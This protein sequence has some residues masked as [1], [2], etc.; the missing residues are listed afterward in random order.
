MKQNKQSLLIIGVT[1]GIGAGKSEVLAY[2]EK[3]YNC[4]VY[5]ADQVAHLVK[6]VGGEAY[7][8]LVELLGEDVLCED[9]S[10]SKNQMAE[11]IFSDQTLLKQ[12]NQIVHPAVKRFILNVIEE[13]KAKQDIELLFIE[14]ALLIEAGYIDVVDELW[15]IFADIETRT[16]RLMANRGYS[17]QKVQSIMDKQLSEKAFRKHC[18][19]VIDNSG[20]LTT[21]YAQIDKKL[22]GYTWL[23]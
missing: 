4:R 17:I 23:E 18:D 15:Y 8:P 12:V 1:G 22:E 14:A 6:E 11:K 2:I 5:L 10:I 7:L 13:A 21:T 9:G 20:E 19:F 16:A 3:H